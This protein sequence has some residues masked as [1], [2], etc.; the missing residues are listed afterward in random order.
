M[1][2]KIQATAILEIMGRPSEHVKEALGLLVARL[3]SEKGVKILDKKHNDP[4]PV[5]DSTNLY[6]AF[7]EL[8]LELDELGNYFGILF[9]YLPSHIEITF[10][11]NLKLTN[12]DLNDTGNKLIQRLHGYDAIVKNTI[13]E[14]E[15]L[16]EKIKEINPELHRKI[17]TPPKSGEE[18]VKINPPVKSKKSREKKSKSK[19]K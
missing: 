14:R 16:L 15:F 17:T 5:K 3:G 2:E 6:T 10:P 8:S 11:E 7:A 9:G 19:N 4:I 18:K 1:S 12:F 13:A